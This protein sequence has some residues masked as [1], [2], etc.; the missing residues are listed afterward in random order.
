VPVQV[1][2]P[3]VLLLSAGVVYL[4][5]EVLASESERAHRAMTARHDSL[6]AERRRADSVLK[7]ATPAL[8]RELMA[9]MERLCEAMRTSNRDSTSL[10]LSAF[11]NREGLVEDWV[12]HV[13]L[14]GASLFLMNSPVDFRHDSMGDS[15]RAEA[16]RLNRRPARFAARLLNTGEVDPCL[17]MFPVEIASLSLLDLT[18]SNVPA[19]P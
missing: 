1:W 9:R 10:D 14:S 11:T 16:E 4:K 7:A 18:A 15:L 3:T 13:H 19:H 12:G 5:I 2:L 6:E 8:Q 17:A